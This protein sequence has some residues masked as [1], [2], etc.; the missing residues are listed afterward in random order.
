[1]R[2]N[3]IVKPLSKL[4]VTEITGLD[5][6]EP[7]DDDLAR[8]IKAL[9]HDA[10][11]ALI[12]RDQTLTPQQHIDFS[13]NFGPL[14]GGPE[15]VPLQD[16]VS[17]YIHPDHP[18]IYRVSNQVDEDGV[19]RGRKSAGTY[20]HSDVSFRENPAAASILHAKQIPEVGGDTLFASGQAAYA[21]LSDAMKTLLAPLSAV[22]DFAV[23]AATQYAK[24]IVIQKDFDG[25]NQTIHPVVRTHH[26][27]AAKSLFVNP[28]FT[29]HLD[30]FD[31]QESDAIL[32]GL[33]AHMTR[34]EYI[35][36]HHWQDRDLVMWDNRLFM[37][38]AIEDYGDEPR[39][40]ERTTVIGERP[41]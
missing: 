26:D 29:S 17:R 40:M 1:M 37:H 38:Y 32:G 5:V 19:P 18:E 15:G 14:F 34:P 39:Y 31:K 30:G 27:T 13:R 2:R 36:R 4:G 33:Y 22:H 23:A 6:S 35:Y 41:H 25:A 8:D 10:G 3:Y 20:W 24:P 9:W 11:G 7:F 16:T 28:G 21:G 12:F